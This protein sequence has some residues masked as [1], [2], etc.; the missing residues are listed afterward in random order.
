MSVP[1]EVLKRVRSGIATIGYARTHWKEALNPNREDGPDYEILGTGF[2]VDPTTI[3]TNRHVLIELEKDSEILDIQNDQYF[4]SF[5]YETEIGLASAFIRMGK[6]TYSPNPTLDIG[7]VDLQMRPDPEYDSVQPLLAIDG[8][9]EVY[10]GQEV[11]VCGF[12]YGTAMLERDGKRYRFGSVL[13]HGFIS[14]LSPYD[15]HVK[16]LLLDVR[17]A[18]GMSGSPVFLP[19]SGVVIGIHHE[20]WEATTAL[21]IPVT[22]VKLRRWLRGHEIAKGG[23][24]IRGRDSNESDD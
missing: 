14:A 13:Q 1:T 8:L 7:F 23:Q 4:V 10:V 17:T 5:V 15:D 21:A 6:Y 22:K 18:G 2:L 19:G 12:P 24:D 9:E 11:C 3:I 16:E 20:G